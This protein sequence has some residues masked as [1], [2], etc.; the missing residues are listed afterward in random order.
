[1]RDRFTASGTVVFSEL[2][3]GFFGIVSEGGE[4]YDPLN[5]DDEFRIDGLRIRFE[6]ELIRDRG[7]IHMWGRLVEILE[8][9]RID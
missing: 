2:E 8:V 6:A 7:S 9:E 4:R 3:G 5:L 1:M